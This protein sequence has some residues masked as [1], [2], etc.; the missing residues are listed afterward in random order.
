MSNNVNQDFIDALQEVTSIIKKCE[1]SQAKFVEG[2]SQYSLL[3]NRIKAMYLSKL[4]IEYELSRNEG[5]AFNQLSV[6]EQELKLDKYIML[7]YTKDDLA[8][9]LPPV[10]SVIHKCEKA[11]SKFEEGTRNHNRFKK[12]IKAMYVSKLLIENHLTKKAN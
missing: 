2:S 7:R 8:E 9:A 5:T 11:Q 6:G 4:L 10:L 3:R 12:L 1:A